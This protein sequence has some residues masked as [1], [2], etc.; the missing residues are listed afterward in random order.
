MVLLRG[1][2]YVGFVAAVIVGWYF[3]KRREARPI[4]NTTEPEINLD[5]LEAII[6]ALDSQRW[7]IRLKAVE[8][9]C[10]D[11]NPQ[12]LQHLVDMLEDPVLD[13]RDAAASGIVAYCTEAVP[14]LAQVLETGKL[15]AREVAV[16]ALCDIGT[17]ATVDVLAKALREDESAWVR[18]PAAQGLG[19]IGGEKASSALRSALDDPHPDVVQTVQKILKR[20]T[21]VTD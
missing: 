1:L 4:H 14:M 19:A 5:T 17:D 7:T 9:L 3:N 6:D 15:N 20:H 18:I 8:A 12:T 10:N 2:L 11:N 16:K 13:V 21:P